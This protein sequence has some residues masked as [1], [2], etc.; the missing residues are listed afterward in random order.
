M[1]MYRYKIFPK[2]WF[3]LSLIVLS[4]WSNVTYAQADT[5]E[6]TL[7]TYYPAPHG[8]YSTLTSGTIAVDRIGVG[9]GINAPADNGVIGLEPRDAAP[10]SVEGNIYYQSNDPNPGEVKF[11]DGTAWVNFIPAAFRVVGSGAFNMAKNS[12]ASGVTLPLGADWDLIIFSGYIEGF[13]YKNPAGSL[14]KYHV[15]LTDINYGSAAVS[16]DAP[17]LD[18]TQ[19]YNDGAGGVNPV[20]DASPIYNIIRIR[21]AT[22]HSDELQLNVITGNTGVVRMTYIKLKF[23]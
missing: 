8:D 18:D 12:A 13:A 21:E 23:S 16:V 22:E 7:T 19:G 6:I 20:V 9:S 1:M 11:Y 5:E 3:I 10:A 14:K 17:R 2:T 15:C 4:A